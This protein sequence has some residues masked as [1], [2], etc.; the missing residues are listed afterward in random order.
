M[1]YTRVS[2]ADLEL[3][4]HRVRVAL[5]QHRMRKLKP[6]LTLI[7]TG[8]RYGT[9]QALIIGSFFD[10]TTYGIVTSDDEPTDKASQDRED[11][12]AQHLE[13]DQY[14]HDKRATCQP[15]H[16]ALASYQGFKVL[17]GERLHAHNYPSTQKMSQKFMELPGEIRNRIYKLFLVVDPEIDLS[18]RASMERRSPA[19]YAVA[20][21]LK[22]KPI[23]RLLR[24]NRQ[25]NS[26]ASDTFYGD[27]EFRFSDQIGWYYLLAFLRKIGPANVAR[28]R[29]LATSVPYKG[30]GGRHDF[31]PVDGPGSG[32]YRIG[33]DDG[34]TKSPGLPACV[35]G[36]IKIL[37]KAGNLEVLRLT[38][39][40]SFQFADD[41][42][43]P[44]KLNVSK[45][46]NVKVVLVQLHDCQTRAEA[47]HFTQTPISEVRNLPGN[48]HELQEFADPKTWAETKGWVYKEAW[49]DYKGAY[50]IH[51]R[52]NCA[53]EQAEFDRAHDVDK[54][55]CH[56]AETVRQ[57]HDLG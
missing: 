29:R 14:E 1:V 20:R 57:W 54:C 7:S 8:R 22:L 24:L 51:D 33:L 44:F 32:L 28:L 10:D 11:D 50:P 16:H 25:I 55:T 34:Q 13:M 31:D 2:D 53:V 21:Y 18:P 23:L 37:E 6:E 38:L 52:K 30:L 47:M 9:T 4:M 12:I 43:K 15:A 46:T 39:P 27:N 5:Y 17:F 42:L 49:F 48:G 40:L 35:R 19:D 36:C 56:I 45:F 26:E 41:Y 3:A